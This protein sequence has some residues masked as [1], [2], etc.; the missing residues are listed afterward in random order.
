MGLRLCPDTYWAGTPDGLYLLTPHGRVRFPGSGVTAWMDRLAP[1]LDGRFTFAEL[2]EPLPAAHREV[3]ERLLRE[4]LDRGALVETVDGADHG[5][6]R[7]LGVLVVGHGPLAEAV[8]RAFRESGVG[9]VSLGDAE[10]IPAVEP[11]GV[12]VVVRVLEEPDPRATGPQPRWRAPSGTV[13]THVLRVGDGDEDTILIG[14]VEGPERHHTWCDAWLRLRGHRPAGDTTEARGQLPSPAPEAA[15]VAAAQLAQRVLRVVT[16]TAETDT[17]EADV[18]TSVDARSLESRRHRFLPH[19]FTHRRAPA[20][21]GD[22]EAAIERA[23]NAPPLDEE[24]MSRRTAPLIDDR[25]GIFA[26]ISEPDV[27]QFPLCVAEARLGNPAG[28]PGLEPPRALGAGLDFATARYAAAMAG[29]AAYGATMIDP[30]RLVDAD[31]DTP[32]P[33]PPSEPLLTELCRGGLH[34]RARA[35]SL[36]TGTPVLVDAASAFP[37]L[38]ATTGRVW[39]VPGSAAGYTWEDA[40]LRGLLDLCRSEVVR[41][42]AAHSPTAVPIDL[43][44]DVLTGAA[45]RYRAM[46]QAI[47]DHWTAWDVTPVLGVPGVLI[48]SGEQLA[49]CACGRSRAD[50]LEDALR[51]AVLRAQTSRDGRT[52]RPAMSSATPAG[53]GTALSLAELVARLGERGY[54]PSVVPLD[55]DPS[56]AALAPETVQVVLHDR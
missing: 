21:S 6:H 24:T 23:R 47:D 18:L 30:R 40:V 11:G 48:R 29:Y 38:R 1:H 9:G 26:E 50:A 15:T 42:W 51:E 49:G 17:A 43:G 22:F 56:V 37:A 32:L 27:E 53:E 46:L 41:H 5:S 28:L 16:T 2:T 7:D 35:H 31:G 54:R 33:A 14:P 45:A 25:C 52:P 12:A 20:D 13:R 10:E 55:H 8:A 3:A 19:P 39:P 34:A 44:G 4:L 36:V